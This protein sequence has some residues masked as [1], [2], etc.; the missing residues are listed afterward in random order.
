MDA[1]LYSYNVKIYP[2]DWFVAV[3]NLSTN[4]GSVYH[5]DNASL[6]SAVLQNGVFC[7]WGSK[8]FDQYIIMG[9]HEGFSP[10]KLYLLQDYLRSGQSY[11]Q[12]P[13]LSNSGWRLQDTD[14]SD[15]TSSYNIPMIAG[16]LNLPIPQYSVPENISRPLTKEEMGSV[17][18]TTIQYNKVISDVASI[19]LPYLEAK[20]AIGNMAGQ[21][22]NG[23][24]YT[25][26]RLSSILLGAGSKPRAYSDARNYR[27]PSN[28]RREY[29]P[30]EL[31][32]FINRIYDKTLTDKEVFNGRK[33]V[34]NIG[35]CD[36]TIAN[37]GIHGSIPQYD[38]NDL[39]S[40]R[41]L[42]ILD[43]SGFYPSVI[44]NNGYMS[45]SV[46]DPSVYASVVATRKQA[47]AEGNKK[48]SDPLK[49]V[50]NCASGSMLSPTNPLYDPLM[51]RSVIISGQLYLTELLNH[52]ATDVSGLKIVQGNTDGFTL[53][54]NES[55][56][57]SI[58]SIINEWQQR[59]G[60]VLEQV[61][62]VSRIVQKDVNNYILLKN[63]GSIT[64]KGGLKKGVSQTTDFKVNNNAPIV[65]EAVVNYIIHGV[66]IEKTISD[67]TDILKFQFISNPHNALRCF[68]VVNGVEQDL[69]LVNRIYASMNNS[70]GSVYTLSV[71]GER[72]KIQGLPDHCIID[73]N[74]E[75]SI[76]DIDKNFYITTACKLTEK[77]IGHPV[78]VVPLSF[79]KLNSIEDAEI[80]IGDFSFDIAPS[81]PDIPSRPSLPAESELHI[82]EEQRGNELISDVDYNNRLA[83]IMPKFV[84]QIMVTYKDSIPDEV[85]AEF[86]DIHKRLLPSW[87]SES[88]LDFGKKEALFDKKGVK[89]CN[90]FSKV[91][92]T[93]YGAFVEI[94]P[95][96]IDDKNVKMIPGEENKVLPENQGRYNVALYTTQDDMSCKIGYRLTDSSKI[97][98][99]KDHYYVSVHE[100]VDN[101]LLQEISNDPVIKLG[102]EKYGVDS[103]YKELEAED[104]P[105]NMEELSNS[106]A[107]I[108]D[109]FI[110]CLK[111][112]YCIFVDTIKE[113]SYLCQCH[114]FFDPSNQPYLSIMRIP[115]SDAA[116]LFKDCRFNID[117]FEDDMFYEA[118][119][120]DVLISDKSF[121]KSIDYV[122]RM[123]EKCPDSLVSS[124]EVAKTLETTL[125]SFD[126]IKKELTEHRGDSN[127][128][129]C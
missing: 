17:V 11:W 37:G 57:S 26:A 107:F 113:K 34:L 89:V 53:E 31:I 28:I 13:G 47:K 93:P 3:R 10:E 64:I 74:N 21:G 85:S 29:I 22:L 78:D 18:D 56:V 84:N 9:I 109:P 50:V 81:T 69:P 62:D 119:H 96:N 103:L 102:L 99:L 61:N 65:S 121:G 6:I 124:G 100:V 19:R 15:D 125:M 68:T 52:L 14:L 106:D 33:L 79:N 76:K 105:F 91:L 71:K 20:E 35:G 32:D 7:G 114:V 39:P 111:K 1:P 41:V 97:G 115:E 44:I 128:I 116:T 51:G 120:E 2:H 8:T 49:T 117:K 126:V 46:N 63:D 112:D 23:L 25:N 42:L 104:K 94:T 110:E 73:N 129:L 59:T 101:A 5:N 122:K 36:I 87:I 77:Y 4:K 30:N 123:V 67:C 92:V 127:G 45:R 72:S 38:S 27:Y 70:R 58:F 86:T 54:C 55:D 48:V 90:G 40:G 66:P 83:E 108:E 82:L 88:M 16:H 80:D 118:Y 24:R 75:L 60:F 95:E 98:Y 43:V 12:F